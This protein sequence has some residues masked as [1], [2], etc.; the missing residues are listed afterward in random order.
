MSHSVFVGGSIAA[1]RL[2][3]PAS[4]Q[5]SLKQPPSSESSEYADRGTAL[6]E[7]MSYLAQR[8]VEGHK[9]APADMVGME[10]AGRIISVEDVRTA[11]QPA[12]E[13][14][15]DIVAQH[16]EGS[17]RGWKIL[18]V[19]SGVRFPGLA[20]YGTADL[21]LASGRRILLVDFKFGQGVPVKA[22]YEIGDEAFVNEQLMFYLAA[23]KNTF[24]KWVGK[25]AM[26]VAV[27]QPAFDE[28][29]TQTDVS[30]A[31]LAD[32]VEAM[33]FSLDNAL[34][35]KPHYARGE[36]CRFAPCKATCPLWTGPLLDLSAIDPNRTALKVS[37]NASNAD[38]GYFLATAKR[39]T[40]SA[41]QYKK[42]I[43]QML[44]DHL[45]AG[46]EADGFAL[47]PKVN[48]RKW[49]N[50]AAQIE[51]EL[52]ALGFTGDEI[53]QSPKLQTFAIADA[54]AKRLGVSIPDHLRPR[55]PSSDVVLTSIDDPD[56]VDPQILTDEFRATL[57]KLSRDSVA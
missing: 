46:G 10:F 22:L 52:T 35:S 32:F 30:H 28:S 21:I 11:I 42:L 34:S 13:A 19:E 27:I 26:T 55:P 29:V 15:W 5:E 3:C 24:P 31:E 14:V 9:V 45:K 33:H 48:D 25:R 18:G 56:R 53:W 16:N 49:I 47:K 2:N 4:F 20:A 12:W 7:G 17:L 38:W 44:L 50:D 41:L 51:D 8:R 37:A 1:R 40:D 57:R 54:A 39:L 23:A 6:H 36:W 43:D